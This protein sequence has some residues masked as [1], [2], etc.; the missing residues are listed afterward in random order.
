MQRPADRTAA[1]GV[2]EIAFL[3]T[4][5]S[6]DRTASATAAHCLRLIAMVER[7]KGESPTHVVT[8][9]EKAKRYPVYEGLANAK[10]LVLGALC[11]IQ[12]KITQLTRQ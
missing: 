6:A 11:D 1:F 7:Q 3:V 8:D 2:A 10:A 4:L 12:R 9:E 5:T